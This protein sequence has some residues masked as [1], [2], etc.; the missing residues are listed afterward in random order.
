MPKYWVNYSRDCGWP[1]R[2]GPNACHKKRKKRP[3]NHIF[4]LKKIKF[5]PNKFFFCTNLLVMRKYWGKQI[6]SL[7]RFPEVGQKQKTEK[8]LQGL[9]LAQAAVTER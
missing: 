4:F 8:I 9:R 2:P 1:R 6:F 7:G 5:T 3:K